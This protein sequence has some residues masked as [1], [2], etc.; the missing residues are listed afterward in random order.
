[1]KVTHRLEKG[2]V[3]T[4]LTLWVDGANIGR[5]TVRND[6]S[7]VL[8]LIVSGLEATGVQRAVDWLLSY[9][10]EQSD[11]GHYDH[12]SP[13]QQR[14]GAIKALAIREASEQMKKALT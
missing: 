9:A 12:G 7:R 4:N 13:R 14:D 5:L 10:R 8:D 6:E 2:P 11:K 1:M 3:H